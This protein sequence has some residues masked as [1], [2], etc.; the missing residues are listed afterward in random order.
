MRLKITK[1][2]PVWLATNLHS[3]ELVLAVDGSPRC[4]EYTLVCVLTLVT[5]RILELIACAG[6]EWPYQRKYVRYLLRT[7]C[8][9]ENKLQLAKN[10]KVAKPLRSSSGLRLM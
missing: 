8:S 10:Y 2:N 7:F 4:H 5:M 9:L 6:Y 3:F 1:L